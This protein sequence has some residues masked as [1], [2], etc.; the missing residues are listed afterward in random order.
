MVIFRL[1]WQPWIFFHNGKFKIHLDIESWI[2]ENYPMKLF[3]FCCIV[4][5]TFWKYTSKKQEKHIFKGFLNKFH[6]SARIC[7]IAPP[8]KKMCFAW[9]LIIH[10]ENVSD[11]QI[12][13]TISLMSTNMSTS[14]NWAKQLGDIKNLDFFFYWVPK[15]IP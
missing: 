12:H 15:V 13:T 4:Q 5:T 7:W 8:L 9:F 6:A 11:I 1:G 14:V 10:F 2:L 3:H